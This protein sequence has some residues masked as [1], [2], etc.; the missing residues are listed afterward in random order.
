L[1]I[2][3]NTGGIASTNCFVLA[4]ESTGRA[5]L[6]DAPDHTTGPLLD[7]VDREGWMLESLFLTHGHF[8]HV[9]DHS[10]VSTRFPDAKVWLHPLDVPKLRF[11][12]ALPFPLP[13]TI[14]AREPDLL[15]NDDQT[16][17]VGSLTGRVMHTPGHSPGHVVF[18]FATEEVLVG[19]D[20]IICG[21]VG[22]TDFPDGDVE[23]LNASVRR[24]IALP[25]ATRLLPGHCDASTLAEEMKSNSYVR[26]LR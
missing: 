20:L 26:R 24:V 13:F 21:S 19:G 22:R 7:A 9:A 10:V 6:F 4:D 2:L 15:L 5:A 17:Q 8:D 14:P 11:P 1:K 3:M 18:Y 16:I 25:A 23:Q 12:H